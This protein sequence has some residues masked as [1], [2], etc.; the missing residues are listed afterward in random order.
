VISDDYPVKAV[1]LGQSPELD[2]LT[3]SVTMEPGVRL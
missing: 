3:A 1:L 2:K